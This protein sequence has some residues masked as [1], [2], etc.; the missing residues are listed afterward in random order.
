MNAVRVLC[1]SLPS[2]LSGEIVARSVSEG[3][4]ELARTCSLT[5]ASGY[6]AEK[7]ET[8]KSV[9]DDEA[10]FPCVPRLR[11]GLLFQPRTPVFLIGKALVLLTVVV[12]QAAPALSQQPPENQ[13]TVLVVVGATGTSEYG[14]Q[15]EQ[16]AARWSSAAKSVGTKSV[17]I[18]LGEPGKSDD[19]TQLQQQLAR[20]GKN[21]TD[22]LWIVL[23]GHGTF[24]G[25]EARFNL[26]G[27]DVTAQEL[28][29]WLKP[30]SRPTAIVNCASSSGAFVPKL[31]APGRAI[32][33]A[34]KSGHESNFARFGDA[35]SQAVGDP[36]ADLDKDGQ[37]SLLEA[38][39]KAS[40]RTAEF[41]ETSGRL[42]TEHA[43]LDDTGD[44]LGTKADWYRGVRAVKKPK[45]GAEAD[46]LRA[47]QFHLVPSASEEQLTPQQRERR[48]ELEQTIDALREKRNDLGEDA[49]YGQLE[50]VLVELAR[51]YENE[52]DDE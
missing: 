5:Y 1:Q 36:A 21:A 40:R 14:K 35:M 10:A 49:Y 30:L 12:A 29:D 26:R 48:N 50:P 15:F 19:K 39:L 22:A 9:C 37:T 27:P 25:R 47:H 17:T 7:C 38:F 34:T 13:A 52:P 3:H 51:L 20:E 45:A 23:I 8:S 28:A 44:G 16:W 4:R 42:A 41:Y 18:G 24:D 32:V 46:G 2:R 11:F 31:S 43:L 6:D 33:A